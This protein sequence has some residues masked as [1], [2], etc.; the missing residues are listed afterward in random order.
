MIVPAASTCSPTEFGTRI[1]PFSNRHLN[2]I[3]L[4]CHRLLIIAQQQ[5][6]SRLPWASLA[7]LGP[8]PRPVHPVWARKNGEKWPFSRA[9]QFFLLGAAVSQHK[10]LIWLLLCRQAF[11]P[12]GRE[13]M[14]GTLDGEFFNELH[15]SEIDSITER[16][17]RDASDVMSN[18]T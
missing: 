4:I 1:M 10:S 14:S 6:P 15:A 5:G 13:K 17:A 7:V 12:R 8:G 11:R 2:Y 3:V 9:R 18:K 16:L